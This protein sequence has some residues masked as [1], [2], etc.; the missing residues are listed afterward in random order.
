MAALI[1]DHHFV[2][3]ERVED[4]FFRKIVSE[5]G[6]EAAGVEAIL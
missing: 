1:P 5:V 6:A 3:R 2:F 4:L